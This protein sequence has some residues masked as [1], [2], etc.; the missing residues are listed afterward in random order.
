MRIVYAAA[1]LALAFTG[2]VLADTVDFNGRVI[3]SG[4]SIGR[5]FDIAGKPDRV[6][7]LQNKFGA[8]VAERFEYYR[9]NKT[10]LIVVQ[11]GKVISIEQTT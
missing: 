9:G 7:Q 10:I 8:G 1:L 3:S 2:P 4:D 5:V 11:G 6:V